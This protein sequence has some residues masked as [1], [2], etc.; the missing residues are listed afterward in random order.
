MELFDAKGQLYER[1]VT[2]KQINGIYPLSLSTQV[3]DQTGTWRISI[4]AGANTFEKSFKIESIK[5]NRLKST[6]VFDNSLLKKNRSH[7]M[8]N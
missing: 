7:L 6:L 5:P 4:K 2:N 8:F 1:R 3:N